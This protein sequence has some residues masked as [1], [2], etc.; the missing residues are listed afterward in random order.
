MSSSQ[1][2]RSIAQ[3]RDA[4]LV[5]DRSGSAATTLEEVAAR[6]AVAITPAMAELIDPHDPDDPIARQ[7]VPDPAE[8]QVARGGAARPDRRRC[9]QPRGRHRP[10]ASRSGA[11]EARARLPCLLPVLFSPRN[12]RPGQ[13][14]AA[15]GAK[16]RRRRKIYPRASRDLGS[17]PYRRR[18][19]GA[20]PPQP[21]PA[22]A[23]LARSITSGL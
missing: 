14:A 1:T 11:P 3:L 23:S 10:P 22:I 15:L 9:F 7:F 20:R 12:G 19:A 18:S 16:A 13:A 5:P 4:G 2:L 21:A 6:Y 17:D 8:L